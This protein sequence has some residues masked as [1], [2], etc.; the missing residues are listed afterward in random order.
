MHGQVGVGYV[1][2]FISSSND[3]KFVVIE[4]TA[5]FHFTHEFHVFVIFFS[6][7]FHNFNDLLFVFCSALNEL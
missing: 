2:P 3:C 1:K 4:K 7:C 6:N 5:K